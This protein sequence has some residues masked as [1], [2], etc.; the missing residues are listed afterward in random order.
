MDSIL[1]F[2]FIIVFF[3]VMIFVTA[4][5]IIMQSLFSR[6]NDLSSIIYIS[7]RIV[8]KFDYNSRI[9]D[10][11]SA[12]SNIATLKGEN[13]KHVDLFRLISFDD[14]D[15]MMNVLF[16]DEN[17]DSS[18]VTTV[19]CRD[20]SK[21]R[22]KFRGINKV[23]YFGA[24]LSYILV[25]EDVTAIEKNI[26]AFAH[27]KKTLENLTINYR[28][29]EEELE[30]NFNQIQAKQLEIEE[31]KFR[32]RQF[33]EKFEEGIIEFEFKSRE[34]NF[35]TSF[36]KYFIPNGNFETVH[37]Q[38][39]LLSVLNFITNDSHFDMIE[40]FYRALYNKDEKFQFDLELISSEEYI[41]V[42]GYIMYK[43][44][45]PIYMYCISKINPI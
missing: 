41:S 45:E 29:A 8:V 21:R 32:H 35:S 34:L 14:Y 15:E 18:F 2:N 3:L 9:I 13:I 42:D 37:S 30:R 19:T 39:A 27:R 33:T 12:F 26:E 24:G 40:S 25:G 28:Y 11:N 16:N 36:I 6:I 1:N 4:C 31:L 22:I 44:D 20:K 43:D 17:K 7:E 38:E 23:D 5:I 10:Y